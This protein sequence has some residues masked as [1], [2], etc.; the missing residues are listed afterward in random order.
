MN[1]T[2]A[3]HV[4]ELVALHTTDFTENKVTIHKIRKTCI[5]DMAN[6]KQLT[7]KEIQEFARHK[8]FKT[9]M[10]CYIFPTDTKKN[11]GSL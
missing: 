8:D 2:L 11:I 4:G 3:L 7:N 6:S 5:S 10:S 1:F 9:T